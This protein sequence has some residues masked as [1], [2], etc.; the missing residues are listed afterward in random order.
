[1]L[2]KQVTDRQKSARAVA[3]AGRDHGA[4]VAASLTAL[5]SPHLQKGEALPDIP[6]LIE[7]TARSLD[8]AELAMT[9]ADEGH[10]S[11]LADDDAPR[12]ARDA[13]AK[14]LSAELVDLREWLTILYGRAA[15]GALGFEAPLS[16]DAIAIERFTGEVIHALTRKPLPTPLRQGVKWDPTATLTKIEALRA[17]LQGHFKDIAREVREAHASL[18]AKNESIAAYD[19]RFGRVTAFLVGLFRFAGKPALAERVRP[20]RRRP[21]LTETDATALGVSGG[22]G[23]P[24][25]G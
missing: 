15:L 17:E 18:R 12:E 13:V 25:E 2:S 10:V 22:P 5:L 8:S 20:S 16:E 23:E 3:S 19:E 24:E 9:T 14:R 11:E 21:G 1:M 4:D 6:L 7:L